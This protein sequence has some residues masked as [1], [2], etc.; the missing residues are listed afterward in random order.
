MRTTPSLLVFTLFSL[1]LTNTQKQ[2]PIPSQQRTTQVFGNWEKL[3]GPFKRLK[4]LKALAKRIR[5]VKRESDAQLC[6]QIASKHDTVADCLNK[7]AK[8]V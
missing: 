4:R 3:G 2:K 6:E 8:G 1:P 7:F 5:Q